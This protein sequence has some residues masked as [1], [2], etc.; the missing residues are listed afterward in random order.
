MFKFTFDGDELDVVHW[1]KYLGLT[2][3]HNGSFKRGAHGPANQASRAN[4]CA[5]IKK[6]ITKTIY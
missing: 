1:Y 2:I 5:V 3:A 6:Q 4:V